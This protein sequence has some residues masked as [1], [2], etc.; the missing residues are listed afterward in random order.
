[1]GCTSP[2]KSKYYRPRNGIEPSMDVPATFSSEE[3]KLLKLMF[4]DVA[5][6]SPDERMTKENFF[7]FFHINVRHE[8][9][10]RDSGVTPSSNGS[11]RTTQERWTLRSFVR[12]SVQNSLNSSGAC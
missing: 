1:M 10:C 9:S 12:A 4:H 11:T 7:T 3:L 5:V 6:R 2:I 8:V